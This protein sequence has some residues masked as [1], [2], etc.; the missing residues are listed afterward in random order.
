MRL[1][2]GVMRWPKGCRARTPPGWS[3]FPARRFT[4][5]SACRSRARDGV[6]VSVSTVGRILAH[7]VM[8]GAVTPVALL[9]RRPGGRRFRFMAGERHARRLPR[10]LKPSRPGECVQIDTLFVNVRPDKAI[11]HFTAYDPVAKWTLARVATRA[12]AQSA[13]ALLDKLI[14][15]A[16]FTI[17]GIQVD[18][19][20]EFRAEFEAACKANNLTLYVLPPKRPEL[21]GAVERAQGSWRYEFYACYDLPFHIDKLQRRLDAFAYHFNPIRPHDALDGQTPA[22]YLNALSAQASQSHMC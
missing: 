12:S 9:R 22:E 16:P 5:G 15:E 3:E 20:S 1:S 8:R 14:A 10:G 17:K 13:A 19:G 18:G 11:K 21:N 2:A 6:A 4:V 7:L